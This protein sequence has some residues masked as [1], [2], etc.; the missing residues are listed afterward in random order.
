MAKTYKYC[1]GSVLKSVTVNMTAGSCTQSSSYD[2]N[3]NTYTTFTKVLT[4]TLDSD[5]P[6][7]LTINYSYT[8][9]YYIRGVLD[10]TEVYNTSTIM[11]AGQITR[12]VTVTCK[13][14]VSVNE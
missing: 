11:P 5:L 12:T 14:I 3:E 7:P 8:S 10:S 13:S 9:N 2:E 1:D 6:V 4:F